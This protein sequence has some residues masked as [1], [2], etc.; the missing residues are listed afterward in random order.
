VKPE[1]LSQR[2]ARGGVWVFAL[3][4][5]EKFLGL[6]R[7]IILARLLAPNDFGLFGIALLV[8]ATLETFSQTGFQTAL[9]QQKGDIARYL[10]TAWTA[11]AIRGTILFIVLFF[12]AP[13]VALFFNTPKA[14]LIIQVIGFS[15]VLNGFTNI[16]V[17]YFQKELEFGR[18]FIYQLSVTLADFIV[19]VSAALAF[20]NVWAFVFGLLAGNITGLV[21]SYVIH[22][23]RPRLRLDIRRAKELFGFGRWIFVSSILAFL[24]TQ[25]DDAF[26]GKILSATMLGF[27]QMAYKIANIPATE[28]TH[29][30]SQVTF[31]AY[32]KIQD[33]LPRLR[34]A[35]L[36][37]LQLT[38]YL[39]FPIA[40][41]IVI[42]APDFTK[43][44]LGEKW[45]PIVPATQV[46]VLWGLIRSIGTA[47]GQIFV[48]IGKPG[49]VTKLQFIALILLGISIYPFSIK[50][51]ILGTSLAVVLATLVS[52]LVAFYIGIRTLQCGTLNFS[53]MILVPLFNTTFSV[54]ILLIVK[55]AYGV[56]LGI[57][58]L[59]LIII[60]FVIFFLGLT[61][62]FD[63]FFKY[64]FFNN[65][66][67]SIHSLIG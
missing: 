49:I 14:S 19:V 59:I 12:S 5:V 56:N 28:I 9:V 58:E 21:V 15:I 40:G 13:Y 38:A 25:G 54:S 31:P 4:G 48:S 63:K 62:F 39:S 53:K 55:A 8:I 57:R 26:V 66:K 41:L 46:L 20:K 61:L 65:L 16:G 29:I 6:V 60:F 50:W 37:V 52:N 2:V 3:R 10:D 67:M 11:C 30:I 33:N 1:S 17:I 27:Y 34:E 36:R 51:G 44:F 32:T 35:Y 45:M 64:Q 24:I 22:P 23:Y 7:L 47:T 43:I 18:Q 42:L